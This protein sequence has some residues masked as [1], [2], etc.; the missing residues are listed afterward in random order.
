MS[1]KYK[2]GKK[3]F[4]FIFSIFLITFL[5]LYFSG[6]AGYVEYE[7]HKKTVLTE[8]Q[9]KKFEKDVASGKNVDVK[10]YLPKDIDNY[11]NTISKAGLK[12]S[13]MAEDFVKTA[14]EGSFKAIAKLVG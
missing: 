6:K 10:D 7:N 2:V 3:I 4:K 9:I 11:Q 1:M 14:V 13:A 8:T 5:V 12:V